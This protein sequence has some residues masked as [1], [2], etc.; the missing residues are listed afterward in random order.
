MSDID[1]NAINDTMELPRIGVT[2]RGDGAL[3]LSWAPQVEAGRTN[4]GDKL[5]GALV[6]TKRMTQRVIDE[7]SRLHRAGHHVA[8]HAGCTGWGGTWLEP[9]V[10]DPTLQVK[11]LAMLLDAG[12][13]AELATLRVDPIVPTP[14]G[15]ARAEAVL[16]TADDLGL[17][18]RVTVRFSVYDEY[19]H[20]KERLRAIGRGPFYPGGAFQ[21][22][23]AQLLDVIAML[24]RALGKHGDAIRLGCCAETR[25]LQLWA[26]KGHGQ[27]TGLA[28]RQEGCVSRS[29]LDAWGVDPDIFGVNP[30][31]R[32]GCL[33][34][35]AKVELLG[36][37]GQCP[38]KCVYCY[39]R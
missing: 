37:R 29:L 5:V 1:A 24:E 13:P 8:V 33:C 11:S 23:D 9:N 6:I 15:I 12:F 16:A 25:L 36:K 34:C 35:G 4:R 22:T 10:P 39:W 26:G 32:D 18:P 17:L 30:Q 7:T 3:D 31:G 14:E 20:V 38:H 27:D 21:A 28:L 19:R 2:E